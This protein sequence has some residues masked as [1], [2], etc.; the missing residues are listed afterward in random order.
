MPLEATNF[1]SQRFQVIQEDLNGNA[2]LF[3]FLLSSSRSALTQFGVTDAI[4]PQNP[5]A[6]ANNRIQEII[7]PLATHRG[8]KLTRDA[9]VRVATAIQ[10]HSEEEVLV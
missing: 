7:E 5:T 1:E 2:A 6:A 8:I 3:D 9:L 10:G 4:D